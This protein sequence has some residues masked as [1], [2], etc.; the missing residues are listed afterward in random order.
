MFVTVLKAL[1][2]SVQDVCRNIKDWIVK[3][4]ILNQALQYAGPNFI[5]NDLYASLKGNGKHADI[6]K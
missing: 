6:C 2:A 4:R 1:V 5:S 3:S